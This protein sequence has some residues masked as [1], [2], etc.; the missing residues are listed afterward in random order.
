MVEGFFLRTFRSIPCFLSEKN[1]NK[2]LSKCSFYD[3][4][5]VKNRNLEFYAMQ[6]YD[7]R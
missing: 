3:Y 2:L 6:R 4:R 5:L 7:Y 1:A